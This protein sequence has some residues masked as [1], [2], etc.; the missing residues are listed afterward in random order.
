MI[1]T[2]LYIFCITR[3][4][5]NL[6]YFYVT[7]YR[8]KYYYLNIH[9]G[10]WDDSILKGCRSKFLCSPS[11]RYDMGSY[12]VQSRNLLCYT[13]VMEIIKNSIRIKNINIWLCSGATAQRLT[14][15]LTVVDSILIRGMNY[16]HFSGNKTRCGMES[17]YSIRNP[18][19]IK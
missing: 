7:F 18:L 6:R 11:K 10:K 14:V 12:W 16:F 9:I 8:L 1:Y 4:E 17:H 5:K 15:N 2:Y 13:T 19:V 3:A